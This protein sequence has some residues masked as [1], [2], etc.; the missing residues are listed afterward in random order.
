V[1]EKIG[2][3]HDRSVA[4]DLGSVTFIASSYLHLRLQTAKPVGAGRS[5]VGNLTPE[6]KKVFDLWTE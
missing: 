3:A 2:Q 6:V 4:F 5:S 1:E